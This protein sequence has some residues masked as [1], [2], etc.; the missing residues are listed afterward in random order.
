[1]TT[2]E[3]TV[4]ANAAPKVIDSIRAKKTLPPKIRAMAIIA[5][6]RI[7]KTK[8]ARYTDMP[9]LIDAFQWS[10]TRD[11]VNFWKMVNDAE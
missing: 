1:M 10:M 4:T 3:L 11:G 9:E 7:A 2:T 8:S 6:R 5:I